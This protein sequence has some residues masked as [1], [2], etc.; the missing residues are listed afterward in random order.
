MFFIL[1]RSG[2]L[3]LE[4]WILLTM[5][6]RVVFS[7]V[8]RGQRQI[9]LQQA[10]ECRSQEEARGTRPKFSEYED[11]ENWDRDEGNADKKCNRKPFSTLGTSDLAMGMNGQAD[12][13]EN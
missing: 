8:I 2:G 4:L 9:I 5:H 12:L 7:R 1:G 13:S 6:I 11:E 3:W 10:H